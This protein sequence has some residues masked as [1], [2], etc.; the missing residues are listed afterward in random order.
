MLSDMKFEL[1][2]IEDFHDGNVEVWF[3]DVISETKDNLKE[4]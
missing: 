4:Q 3:K 2:A 1:D